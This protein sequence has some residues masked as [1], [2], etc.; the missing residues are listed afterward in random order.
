MAKALDSMSNENIRNLAKDTKNP[1]RYENECAYILSNRVCPLFANTSIYWQRNNSN[2][3]SR[4]QHEDINAVGYGPLQETKQ[5]PTTKVEKQTRHA[6][7]ESSISKEEQRRLLPSESR[8]PRL[9]GLRKIHKPGN[10]L[11]PIVAQYTESFVKNSE[12][13]IEI[14][15]QHEVTKEY[16]LVSFDV[17]SL[18]TNV[19]VEETLEIIK[20]QLTPKGLQPDVKFGETLP[21]FDLLPMERSILRTSECRM[22]PKWWYRYVDDTFAIWPHGPRT[23]AEFLQHINRQHANV[24]F[25]MEI[26]EDDNLP[27]LDVL[28]ERTDSNKLGHS[29]DGEGKEE[30]TGISG[31]SYRVRREAKR[32]TPPG[33]SPKRWKDRWGSLSQEIKESQLQNR[34]TDLLK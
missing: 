24:N 9:Y 33:R 8:P 26:E 4:L 14:P 1:R 28:V 32:V 2:G 31:S 27:I 12:H 7:K 18:F 20:Q 23:L 15:Q 16:L 3:S 11:R 5:G 13:F 29:S 17:E 10:P 19:P 21:Y 22:K 30:N 25:T 34:S 6:I